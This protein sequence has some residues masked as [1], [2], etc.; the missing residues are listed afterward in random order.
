MLKGIKLRQNARG[1]AARVKAPKRSYNV[2][3]TRMSGS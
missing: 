3:A 1:A 2:Q